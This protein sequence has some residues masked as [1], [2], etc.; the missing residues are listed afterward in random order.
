[1]KITRN[2]LKQIIKETILYESINALIKKHATANK[3]IN[4]A[5]A[6]AI[7]DSEEQGLGFSSDD[8]L[9]AMEDYYDG[10]MTDL[11]H[12]GDD[13]EDTAGEIDSIIDD[14]EEPT[15][16]DDELQ[17]AADDLA[18]AFAAGPEGVRSF[19]DSQG[20]KDPAVQK[21]L[22]TA[23]EEDVVDIGSAEPLNVSDLGPTQQ[24]IDLMQSVS[25]PL[26]SASA[27]DGAI[28]SKTTGAP[29]SISVS[30]GV[31]LDGHHRWSGVYAITP[32]GTVSAKNFGFSGGTRDKLASA[33][34]AIAVINNSGTHPSK[35]GG[36]STDIIGKGEEEIK[37]MIATNKGEQTDANA[38]GA[39]LNDEMIQQIASGEYP[40][41]FE[42]AG[43]AGSE[44]FVSLE[45]SADDLSNDPIRD[46][47]ASRVA[48]NL[49]SLPQPVEGAPA[50][51]EDMPQL[52]HDSIGGNVGL[53]AIV[54][55]LPAGEYNVT[56]GFDT[57]L[58]EVALKRWQLIAGI[59]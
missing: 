39:L 51:R 30:D 5:A 48:L 35:G 58:T 40:S 16:S 22:V 31:I 14:K 2:Q 15:I 57:A 17:N 44:K 46:A 20:N 10:M 49:S 54:A 13:T 18:A 6:S 9:D 4:D 36:S 45:D 56:P 59:K 19:M 26:G 37:Q 33:Q 25:F 47:I 8:I 34:L 21:V 55:A 32:D 28:T 24:F 42:W 11:D 23:S 43:L 52:D 27:L 50:S 7:T 12:D 53:D 41:I 38:P 3:S 1:M 29:G